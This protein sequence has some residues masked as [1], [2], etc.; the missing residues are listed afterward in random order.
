MAV[1]IRVAT[2]GDGGTAVWQFMDFSG[3]YSGRPTG[4]DP[5]DRQHMVQV[6][7]EM[8]TEIAG[9]EPID[10]NAKLRYIQT[11]HRNLNLPDSS[12]F[13]QLSFEIMMNSHPRFQQAQ[14]GMRTPPRGTM[15]AMDESPN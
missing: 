8:W 4:I 6:L 5:G 13:G 1:G 10:N 3:G 14:G 2:T 9:T 11:L 7:N 12:H 15:G